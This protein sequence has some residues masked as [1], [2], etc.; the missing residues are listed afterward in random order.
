[1]TSVK[2][3]PSI[4][5]CVLD[6]VNHFII[7]WLNSTEVVDFKFIEVDGG[8]DESQAEEG[9]CGEA[10]NNS[11]PRNSR[12]NDYITVVVRF[13]STSN[14]LGLFNSNMYQL[15]KRTICEI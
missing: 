4:F 11:L 3:L 6:F 15:Y 10:E 5:Y 9:E 8:C 1:M 7:F 13:Q 14:V 12:R 2:K